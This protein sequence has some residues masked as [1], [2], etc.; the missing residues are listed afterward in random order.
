MSNHIGK[1]PVSRSVAQFSTF[2]GE[3]GHLFYDISNGNLR[4]SDGSTPGGVPINVAV[5]AA[6]IGD[7]VINSSTISTLN[8]NENIVLQSNGTGEISVIGSFMVHTPGG[9]QILEIADNGEVKFL[10]PTTGSYNPAFSVVGNSTGASQNPQNTGVIFQTTGQLNAPSR[11]YNDGVGNYAAY[12]GRRYNGTSA[13]PTGMTYS[14][15]NYTNNVISRFG[16]TQYTS[17]GWPTISTAR[18]D[19]NIRETATGIAQ[20]TEIQFWTTDIG[21]TT[22]APQ[23]IINNQGIS[24]NA[25][26]LPLTTNSYDLGSVD[27]RWNNLY[28]GPHSIH[29]Q[30]TN[31]L[32]D[33]ELKVTNGT[34]YLNGAQNI[35]LGDLRIDGLTLQS[36]LP[37]LNINLGDPADTG[38]F[39]VG[40]QTVITTPN[41]GSFTSALV[42]NGATTALNDPSPLTFNGTLVHG[43]AQD[44]QNARLVFDTFGTGL[45]NSFVGRY[46]RGTI[47]SPSAVQNND[48][49]LR[50]SANG[51]GSSGFASGGSARID[52][53]ASENFTDSTKG[54]RID[55]WTTPVGS[56]TITKNASVSN[57]GFVGTGIRFTGD[58]SYQT[59]AGIPLTAKG[60]SSATQVATLGVDGKLDASQIPTSL[61][62]AVVFKGAWDASTNTPTLSNSLPAG[63]EAG[64]EYVVTGPGTLDIGDGSQLYV[65]G[66]FVIYDGTHWKHIVSANAFTYMK[67]ATG[68]H[69]TVNGTVNTNEV[70]A[71][72]ISSDAT[73]VSTVSTI[74]SRDSSGNFAAN[75]ITALLSGNVTGNVTG[76][77]SGNA[78]TVT[79]GVYTTGSYADPSWITSIASTKITGTV[80][81]TNGVIT[82]GSYADPSWITSLAGSKITGTVSS[83]SNATTVTNGVYTNGSYADPSWITSLAGT[84]I[85]GNISGQAGSVANGF[86]TSSTFNLG[87]TSIA[88]NRASG[89]QSL[90]GISIDGN[91]GT[92][93]NGV[94][95]SGSYSDPSWITGLA[96]TK[97]TGTVANATN[98]GNAT[99]VTSITSSQVTTA[100]GFTPYNATNPSSYI[101]LTAL[102]VGTP[103]AASGSGAISYVNT[104]GVFTYTPPLNIT[105]NAATV[106]NGVYTSGSYSDPSWLTLSKSKVGLSNVDNTADANKNVLYAT[107]AGGAPATDVYAWAKAATKPTY[108]KSEVGLSAVENTALS[109]WAGSTNITTVGTLGS[110][111]VTA[112]ITGSVSGNAGTVTN[113]VYTSGSYSDPSWLTISKSKVGLSAV[114]NTALSTWAGTSSIT[115]VGTLTSGT[116]GSGFTAIA[117]ARLANSTISGVA[118][119]GTLGALTVGYGLQLESGTT[120]D[121]SAAHTISNVHAVTGPVTV[122]GNAYSLDLGTCNGVVILNNVSQANYTV[123]ITGTPVA[124]KIVRLVCLNMKTGAGATT[125]SVS[126]LT[127][128]N[129]SNGTAS[130]QGNANNSV[131]MVEL[132]CTTT[133]LSGVYMNTGGAK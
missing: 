101:A 111:S 97:I 10:A 87:T 91:A 57:D 77:V 93:T 126:G 62:G 23:L 127:A 13:S 16:A 9:Q 20:G 103:N 105:G 114:E 47:V 58:D 129:S 48:I 32:A 75:I 27:L 43:V 39:T 100:L 95:T 29:L 46:A 36:R 74:V 55:F 24:H 56:A 22:I 63:L 4:L 5:S 33:I 131:A 88:V 121:G 17:A 115:T 122:T 37:S 12:I 31:T 117:N 119:G 14:G 76:N 90:T 68:G 41:L 94:Y 81:A 35:A 40:R 106:T 19:F 34:L 28:M 15:S 125:V 42:I 124:G 83:A 82:T 18:I 92:V 128:A 45:Y 30:D 50:V 51:W 109:T 60:N 98:A 130:F 66:D 65:A 3:R 78:G 6:N 72:V 112:T 86:Y 8:A 52:F 26:I 118:L 79:N 113:G 59:T 84:K 1:I 38:L 54:T 108:T 53:M 116:I 69:L 71:L 49:I 120:Y 133:A 7:L 132:V 85:T 25:N 61:S 110:L 123:T 21:S 67:S 102:S 11:H 70:G 80:T 99:T 104:T 107:T 73:P 64:W 2:V 44:G 89:A 96:G